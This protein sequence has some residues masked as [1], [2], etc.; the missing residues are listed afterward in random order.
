MGQDATLT[1][2]GRHA[3]DVR[4]WRER[5]RGRA[6]RLAH[7]I[8]RRGASLLF[9]A[10]LDAV[11]AWSLAT[12]PPLVEAAPA[13][14][15]IDRLMPLPV[16]AALWAAVGAVCA[17]QAFVHNDQ[18]AYT[19]AVALKLGWGGS[20]LFAWVAYQ[21]PRGYVSAAVWLAFG[22]WVFIISGWAEGSRRT[23]GGPP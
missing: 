14:L 5:W 20:H 7:R 21:V 23:N 10:M 19:L 4:R 9:L 13:Y 3:A 11:F 12:V 1:P 15:F 2:A 22:S 17:V 18:I 16:W 6:R 8:G